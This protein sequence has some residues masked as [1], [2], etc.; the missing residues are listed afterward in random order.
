MS[1]VGNDTSKTQRISKACDSCR[2]G[3]VR[4]G[5]QKPACTRCS[6][7]DLE[8]AYTTPRLHR[9][10][11]R[12]GMPQ[13]GK[14][15][16]PRMDTVET[17]LR[18]VLDALR[19]DR[20]RSG[21]TTNHQSRL[22]EDQNCLPRSNRQDGRGDEHVEAGGNAMRTRGDPERQSSPQRERPS[23][24]PATV[25]RVRSQSILQTTQE[26]SPIPSPS[27]IGSTPRTGVARLQHPIEHESRK[28]PRNDCTSFTAT[29]STASPIPLL[30]VDAY[31]RY[32]S[33]L[34]SSHHI[35]LAFPIPTYIDTENRH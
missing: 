27:Y 22:A 20:D 19:K 35:R 1:S 14:H 7:N 21:T 5:G 24:S 28:R 18:D 13:T 30:S 3:K 8:C 6:E 26:L 16:S 32:P 25:A 34:A 12:G 11:E 31:S 29:T 23:S 17:M 10:P 4:C 33:S 2:K 9:G 15:M